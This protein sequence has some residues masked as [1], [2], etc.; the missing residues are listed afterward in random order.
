MRYAIWGDMHGKDLGSLDQ[1]LEDI[2]PDVLICLGDFDQVKVIQQ[3]MD[4]QK[5][6][7]SIGKEVIVVPGNHDHAILVNLDI[8]S[9][10]I[11]AQGK[12]SQQLHD[13][14]MDS[15]LEDKFLEKLVFNSESSNSEH[16][17][18]TFALDPEKFDSRYPTIVVHGALAGNSSSYLFCPKNFKPLWF[19]LRSKSNLKAN[20]AAMKNKN[21]KVMIRGHDHQH[22]YVY[23][24]PQKGI[25][26]YEPR[27]DSEYRLF[28]HRSHVINPGAYFDGY[29]AH[30]D[31]SGNVPV[32]RYFKVDTK[33]VE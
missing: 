4:L 23:D 8:Y 6:Y 11:T 10:T 3:F 31:T 25:V 9:G 17:K 19:R 27:L 33:F 15:P 29:F 20:F 7:Q 5:K 22:L 18:R 24:D 14:L 21:F 32:L 26:T 28:Q 30:I 12:S 2:D 1:A 16:L 13:E